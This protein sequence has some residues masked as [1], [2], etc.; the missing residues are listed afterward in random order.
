MRDGPEEPMYHS[1]LSVQCC[2]HGG[3]LFPG[4]MMRTAT[5]RV[6]GADGVGEIRPDELSAT[7][8]GNNLTR[9]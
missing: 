2:Y 8:R 3:G 4:L 9:A 5:V 7:F 1:I 6:S